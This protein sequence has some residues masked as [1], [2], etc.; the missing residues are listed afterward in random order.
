MNQRPPAR[1]RQIVVGA[2]SN[3]VAAIRAPRELVSTGEAGKHSAVEAVSKITFAIQSPDG[4]QPEVGAGQDRTGD[5][6]SFHRQF[7]GANRT[8]L[9][10]D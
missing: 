10:D 4:F 9:T 2:N 1:L 8:G 7:R 6:F 5:H 3:V